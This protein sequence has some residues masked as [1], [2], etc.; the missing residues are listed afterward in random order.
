MGRTGRDKK[1]IGL[2]KPQ[3][4]RERCGAPEPP[5]VEKFW[6]Q[7]LRPVLPPGQGEVLRV[8]VPYAVK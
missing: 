5:P 1:P 4:S 7:V 6:E 8:S 3:L 2:S